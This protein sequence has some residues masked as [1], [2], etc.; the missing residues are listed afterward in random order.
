MDCKLTLAM[1]AT[2][3]TLAKEL[4]TKH[5]PQLRGQVQE[6]HLLEVVS[7]PDPPILQ[8]WMYYIT[9]TQNR[10]VWERDYC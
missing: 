3:I 10:R 4:S 2:A 5:Q 6:K 9:S 8:R 1:V 7:S